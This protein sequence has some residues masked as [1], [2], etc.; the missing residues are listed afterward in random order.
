MTRQGLYPITLATVV[1]TVLVL[2]QGWLAPRSAQARQPE[3][4]RQLR[5]ADADSTDTAWRWRQ[6][7]PQ[8]WRTCLLQH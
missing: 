4:K 2:S 5:T 8:H 7:Q 3:P 6:G 1:L